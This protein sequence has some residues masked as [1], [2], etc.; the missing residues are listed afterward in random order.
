MS[1]KTFYCAPLSLCTFHKTVLLRERKR[2]TARRVAST[3]YAVPVGGYPPPILGPDLDGGGVPPSQVWMKGGGVGIPFRSGRRGS[4]V[5]LPGLDGGYPILLMGMG[6]PTRP[7][8][9]RGYPLV[10]TWEGGTPHPDLG[11]CTP[12]P[13]LGRSTPCQ[14]RWGYPHQLDGVP[15]QNVNR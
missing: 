4:W 13:D 6:V 9:G 2:H 15:S 1:R 8:L 5:P 7:D 3:R 12:Y 10:Q 14:E 11:R